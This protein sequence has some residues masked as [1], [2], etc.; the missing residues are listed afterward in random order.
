M[1]VQPRMAGQYVGSGDYSAEEANEYN[2]LG[3]R[4]N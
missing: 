1:N 3:K 4:F 2:I